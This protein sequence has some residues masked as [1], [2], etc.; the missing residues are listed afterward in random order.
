MGTVNFVNFPFML[1]PQRGDLLR[2]QLR[3]SQQKGDGTLK[4]SHLLECMAMVLDTTTM[5]QAGYCTGQ[6]F[7]DHRKFVEQL[8]SKL[9]K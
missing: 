8:A 5:H 3:H 7:H 6:T 9:C 1:A 2:S 4:K